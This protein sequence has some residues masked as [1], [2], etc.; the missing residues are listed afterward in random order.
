MKDSLIFYTLLLFCLIS[1]CKD[2]DIKLE[3]KNESRLGVC[4]KTVDLQYGPFY[5]DTAIS[6][7]ST[8]AYIESRDKIYYP[9][10]SDLQ[11]YFDFLPAD[12]FS[13]FIFSEDTVDNYPWEK[14]REDY[15]VLKR[16][17][18][19]QEDLIRLDFKIT[20]PPNPKMRDVKMFPPYIE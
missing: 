3:I 8:Y 9:L 1:G 5:P 7:Y 19:S 10:P 18:L 6:K 4:I 20:Y 17:D 15:R 11:I 13:I 12:T 16:Y 2:D 14:I